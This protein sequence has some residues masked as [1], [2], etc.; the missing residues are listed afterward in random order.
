M[1]RGVEM[2]GENWIIYWIF[3]PREA[4]CPRA[5]QSRRRGEVGYLG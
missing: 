2:T 1:V 4:K 5:M 3:V